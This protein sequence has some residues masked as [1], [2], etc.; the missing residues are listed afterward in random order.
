MFYPVTQADFPDVGP[1]SS[2]LVGLV[3]EILTPRSSDEMNNA[4]VAY[5]AGAAL[6]VTLGAAYGVSVS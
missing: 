3:V 2:V 5:V 1:L 6:V 4:L